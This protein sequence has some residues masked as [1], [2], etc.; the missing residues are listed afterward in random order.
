LDSPTTP[1]ETVMAKYADPM[2]LPGPT[3]ATKTRV[4]YGK[5]D[6]PNGKEGDYEAVRAHMAKS[7]KGRK[8]LAVA[9]NTVPMKIEV[10][11]YSDKEPP[12][13]LGG[14]GRVLYPAVGQTFPKRRYFPK[15]REDKVIS[16]FPTDQG[17]I[18]QEGGTISAATIGAHEIAHAVRMN[19]DGGVPAFYGRREMNNGWQNSEENDVIRKVEADVAKA[20]GETGNRD[21]YLD[22]G[23]FRTSHITSSEPK[24]E[25]TAR[26]LAEHAPQL[27][28][29]TAEMDKAGTG[30]YFPHEEE[31]QLVTQRGDAAYELKSQVEDNDARAWTLDLAQQGLSDQ[32]IMTRLNL[33]RAQVHETLA[34]SAVEMN[35]QGMS[36][37]DIANRLHLRLGQVEYALARH[38]AV[39]LAKQGTPSETIAT[40]LNLPSDQVS[41][42]L[43]HAALDM[44]QQGTSAEDI[45]EHLHLPPDQVKTALNE[46]LAARMVHDFIANGTPAEN[47]VESTGRIFNLSTNQV[48]D[49]LNRRTLPPTALGLD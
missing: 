18:T 29:L 42:M 11:P 1:D 39:N 38:N 45:A 27:Q 48:L 33:G 24:D 49:R 7:Q 8:Y 26:L 40:R 2:N 20:N 47:A 14:K 41:R 17:I 19:K 28:R 25:G 43:D 36:S 6:V 5:V 9:E 31:H 13:A 21:I 22:A 44:L 35:G 34:R 16:T 10:H 23:Y 37:Q 12:E 46:A 15:L 4:S 3:K 32:A 30:P